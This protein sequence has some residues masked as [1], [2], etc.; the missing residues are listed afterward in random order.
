LLIGV[1]ADGENK[2]GK[3]DSWVHSV[4]ECGIGRHKVGAS[5]ASFFGWSKKYAESHVFK[6]RSVFRSATSGAR[7]F[8]HV[9]D[10]V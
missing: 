7:I 5:R 8:G 6:L 10:E 2:R 4:L 9:R 3:R 1:A